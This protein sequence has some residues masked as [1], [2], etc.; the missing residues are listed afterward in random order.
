[1]GCSFHSS[2][3]WPQQLKGSCDSWLPGPARSLCILCPALKLSKSAGCPQILPL[4]WVLCHSCGKRGLCCEA[5]K[6]LGYILG[7]NTS[8]LRFS[9]F[10]IYFE[11]LFL[12]QLPSIHTSGLGSR[13]VCAFSKTIRGKPQRI[14]SASFPL[15]AGGKKSTSYSVCEEIVL[16]NM[17]YSL[18]LWF[19]CGLFSF[20]NQ[21]LDIQNQFFRF[22]TVLKNNISFSLIL[23]HAIQKCFG[24]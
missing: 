10:S 19:S 22:K 20:S 7:R 12:S 5:C 1:M 21:A 16:T 6:F 9:S 15:L 18:P 13:T 11:L 23:C 4:R 2:V 24:F 8:A 3:H 17:A 14:H